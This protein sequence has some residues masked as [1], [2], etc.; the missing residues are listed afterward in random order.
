MTEGYTTR[1]GGRVASANKLN[2]LELDP[3]HVSCP[4]ESTAFNELTNERDDALSAV[5]VGRRQVDFIAEHHEPATNLRRGEDDAMV[6][7]RDTGNPAKKLLRR[8]A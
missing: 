6:P 1:I 5:L 8:H 4:P 7:Y 3:S 2:A